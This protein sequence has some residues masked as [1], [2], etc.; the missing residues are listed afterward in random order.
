MICELLD[1]VYFLCICLR[2]WYLTVYPSAESVFVPTYAP[3][4]TI[5]VRAELLVSLCDQI[6]RLGQYILFK[7]F[8]IME[9]RFKSYHFS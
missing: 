7:P 2:Q 9:K 8:T 1:I 3:F 5:L 6:L 4:I